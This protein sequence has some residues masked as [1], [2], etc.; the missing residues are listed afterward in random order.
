MIN[1][2]NK[3]NPFFDFLKGISIIFVLFHH[4][5]PT[6]ILY[7][8]NFWFYLAQAVPIF[9][10]IQGYH[11]M[12]KLDTIS[13][14]D[15]YG[16]KSIQKISGRIIIPFS[17][18]LLASF[19]L[20][21]FLG[22]FNIVNFIK[23]GGYGPGA[24]YPYIYIQAW[25]ILP[26]LS[27]IIRKSNI[28]ISFILVLSFCIL[29]EYLSNIL[30]LPKYAYRL[31]VFKFVFILYLGCIWYKYGIP[32]FIYPLSLI[33][34]VFFTINI[35]TIHNIVIFYKYGTKQSY[36]ITYFYTFTFVSLLQYL[37]NK[38]SETKITSFIK[39]IGKHSYGIF[40]TQMLIFEITPYIYKTQIL[41]QIT[42]ILRQIIN[43]I[44]SLL[45]GILY[46]K[47]SKK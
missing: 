37:F 3:Y 32:K 10:M 28:A 16:L 17:I 18:I 19:I 1:K 5:I 36:W 23:Q 24:Y 4:A 15:Y 21:Y 11:A 34:I 12:R 9:L 13:L 39:S 30:D 27:F 22:Y 47:S 25:L 33:S 8:I 41:T 35:D 31:L 44:S 6:N 20:S 7:S 26:I 42:N 45:V 29:S 38:I 43:I 46:D 2:N 40:L 14:S